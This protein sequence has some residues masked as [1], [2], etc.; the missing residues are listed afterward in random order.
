MLCVLLMGAGCYHH[1]LF[2]EGEPQTDADFGTDIVNDADVD[3]GLH[4]MDDAD[5]VLDV[6]ADA[7]EDANDSVPI[8]D[9]S[10]RCAEDVA[11]VVAEGEPGCQWLE[12]ESTEG[13]IACPGPHNSGVVQG[14][15]VLVSV[16]RS[17]EWSLLVRGNIEESER[18][19]Y[20]FV[21]DEVCESC[22]W[23][24]CASGGDPTQQGVGEGRPGP[25]E[26]RLVIDN[27]GGPARLR[28]CSPPL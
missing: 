21:D 4:I 14:T 27:A 13:D 17:G 9:G 25:E 5:A 20:A 15:S 12:L 8:D 18:I 1:R 24:A 3:V 6:D 28:V 7:D 16:R 23:Q 10:P 11:V 19:C 22:Q 2:D 26:L